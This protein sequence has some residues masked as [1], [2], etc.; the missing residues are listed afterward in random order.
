MWGTGYDI[1]RLQV[2]IIN[3]NSSRETVTSVT[4]RLLHI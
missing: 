4:A 3:S 1:V 2:D